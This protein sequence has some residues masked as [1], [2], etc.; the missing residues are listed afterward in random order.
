I[1]AD[2]LYCGDYDDFDLAN[3]NDTLED[4][5]HSPKI[6]KPASRGP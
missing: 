6:E 1:F 5:L 2:E 3:E 4:F